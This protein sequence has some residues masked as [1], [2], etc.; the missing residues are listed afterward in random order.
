MIRRCLA[1]LMC[2]VLLLA[3]SGW[4]DDP[5]PEKEGGSLRLKRKNRGT[6]PPAGDPGKGEP[7]KGPPKPPAEVDKG[8]E[9]G[10]EPLVPEDGPP[11]E[12]ETDEQELLERIG[13]NMRAVEDKLSNRELGDATRQQQRDILRDLDALIKRAENPQGGGSDS[14]PQ[15]Q[16][17]GGNRDQEKQ[18]ARQQSGARQQAGSRGERDGRARRH[19]RGSGRQQ[20]AGKEKGGEG[21]VTAGMRPQPGTGS[22]RLPMPGGNRPGAGG[23]GPAGGPDIDVEIYKDVWGH[24][25]EALRA[26]MNA[27][28]NP[29]PFLPRYDRLI[30]EY[31]KTIAEQGRKKGD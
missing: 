6:A 31:Y 28:S 16:Q 17:Q 29:Q 27:Y 13:R 5:A 23:G 4:G 22:P 11:A 30:R 7:D 1:G 12:A 10:D 18:S 24:L 20:R 21:K 9:A 14:R 15:P 2:A 3:G 8:K 19:P 25:P 26:E